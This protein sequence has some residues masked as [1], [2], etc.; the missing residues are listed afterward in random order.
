MM[1]LIQE[2]LELTKV[3]ATTD[4]ADKKS[5]KTHNKSVDRIYE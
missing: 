5:V 4:Y 2:Y 3:C 1:N